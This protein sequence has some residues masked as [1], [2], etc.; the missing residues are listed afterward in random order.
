MTEAGAMTHHGLKPAQNKP[1]P[2]R[3]VA[4]ATCPRPTRRLS[5]NTRLGAVTVVPFRNDASPAHAAVV[6]RR[7]ANGAGSAAVS[8]AT[9]ASCGR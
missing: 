8:S 7:T 9:L 2:G 1:R 5:L 6:A 3:A 4:R